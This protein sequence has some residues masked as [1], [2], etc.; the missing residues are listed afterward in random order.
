[1]ATLLP[2]KGLM[3]QRPSA[4]LMTSSSLKCD[5]GLTV[6]QSLM[7]RPLPGPWREPSN[8]TIKPGEGEE[9]SSRVEAAGQLYSWRKT[10]GGREGKGV[11]A[12]S[13]CRLT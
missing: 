10:K 9:E 4:R 1:M 11:G 13:I 2:E 3:L 7:P 5:G 12:V 6:G 8:G